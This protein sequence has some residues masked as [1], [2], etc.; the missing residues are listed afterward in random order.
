VEDEKERLRQERCRLQVA[1]ASP[2]QRGA[3][4]AAHAHGRVDVPHV[5]LASAK[6]PSMTC[7]T[8]TLRTPQSS[9]RPRSS[10][11]PTTRGRPGHRGQATQH[12]PDR[13]SRLGQP[14]ARG[15]R[16]GDRRGR[17][18]PCEVAVRKAPL[19]QTGGACLAHPR[20]EVTTVSRERFLLSFAM[21]LVCRA[22]ASF[23]PQ[24]L[25]LERSCL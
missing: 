21:L 8:A 15:G 24:R 17:R 18:G 2:P 23:S 12:K 16:D 25:K 13:A 11:T 1:A 5:R 20:F 6:R 9:G 22:S 7:R 19:L 14:D 3:S 4:L 10:C